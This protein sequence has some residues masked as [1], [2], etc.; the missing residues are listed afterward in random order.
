MTFR[1]GRS[2]ALIVGMGLATT[3]CTQIRDHQGYLVDDVLVASV[4]PGV[5]NRES[6]QGTLGRP[7]FTGQFD[8]RDWYYVSRDTKQLA[9]KMPKPTAQTVLHIR[10]D[11]A[12]NVVEVNKTGLEQVASITPMDDKTPVMGRDRGFFEELFGNIGQVGA[13]GLPGQTADNPQ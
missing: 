1:F 9:F 2:F 4:Q 5:D 3:A 13:A 7:T 8:Q 6:V 10:F 11:E 12:G